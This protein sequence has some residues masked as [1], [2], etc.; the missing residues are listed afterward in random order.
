[1]D[2]PLL[3][4]RNETVNVILTH[5]G[6]Q[7]AEMGIRY[8]VKLDIP[9]HVFVEKADLAVLFGNLLENAVEACSRM[10]G[11]RFITV[12]GVASRP[13][14][15]QNSLTL[16]V[17]NSCAAQPQVGEGG[18]FRSSKHGGEGIGISSV[19]SIVERY[20]GVCSFAAK[21]GVFTASLILYQ[22]T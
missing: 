18:S 20:G 2:R 16:V 15:A 4:C 5:F 1:M 22:R 21:D 10:E 19:R 17:E 8:T 14:A 13:D 3:Y 6:D 11:E 9:E 7:A 12:S